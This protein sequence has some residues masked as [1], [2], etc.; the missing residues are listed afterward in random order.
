M[1]RIELHVYVR[2]S[3]KSDDDDVHPTV[4]LLVLLDSAEV[5]RQLRSSPT[6]WHNFDCL[7]SKNVPYPVLRMRRTRGTWELV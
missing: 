7:T 1:E 6:V 2:Y 4:V 5:L 3:N